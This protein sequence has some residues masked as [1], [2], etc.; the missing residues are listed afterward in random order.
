MET[1]K[2][3]QDQLE[4]KEREAVELAEPE[5]AE[6]SDSEEL[7]ITEREY[8][9]IDEAEALEKLGHDPEAIRMEEA[10]EILL[11]S[12][13]PKPEP[14]VFITDDDAEKFGGAFK[15]LK[16]KTKADVHKMLTEQNRYIGRIQQ[17]L[18]ELKNSKQKPEPEYEDN[19]DSEEFPDIIELSPAEQARVIE[20][21]IEKKVRE[22]LA[23][24]RDNPPKS[25]EQEAE[26]NRRLTLE[27]VKK[28]IPSDMDESEVFDMWVE[29]NRNYIDDKA[30]ALYNQNPDLF[31]KHISDYA[32]VLK[33]KKQ[34]LKKQQ[35]RETGKKTAENLKNAE[36]YRQ[37]AEFNPAARKSAGGTGD[38]AMDR[39]ISKIIERNAPR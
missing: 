7:D 13:Q 21:R 23:R 10:R 36:K 26:D 31:V 34:A 12:E 27:V 8:L 17:E 1:V 24:L 20:Q 19:D 29:D 2:K 15:M 5:E 39:A 37:K 16:G 25:R 14:E 3:D 38:P 9:T 33:S 30:I 4:V 28:A 11:N 18:S 6:E 32:L 22:E 35:L